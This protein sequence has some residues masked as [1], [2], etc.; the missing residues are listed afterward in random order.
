VLNPANTGRPTQYGITG[1]KA[2]SFGE[3]RGADAVT[4]VTALPV[5]RSV[6]ACGS[7]IAKHRINYGADGGPVFCDCV[8]QCLLACLGT[9]PQLIDGNFSVADPEDF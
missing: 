8:V 4:V 2:S 7:S 1:Y 6:G 9:C 3:G 5:N